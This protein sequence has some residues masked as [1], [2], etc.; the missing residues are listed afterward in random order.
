MKINELFCVGLCK[1]YNVKSNSLE[2]YSI[3]IKLVFRNAQ[4]M[5]EHLGNGYDKYFKIDYSTLQPALSGRLCRRQRF[6]LLII[7]SLDLDTLSP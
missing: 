7:S 6:K 2:I 1:Q 5:A 4:G 3:S